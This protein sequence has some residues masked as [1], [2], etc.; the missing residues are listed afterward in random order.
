[1]TSA[2][3]NLKHNVKIL[4]AF[5]RLVNELRLP[6]ARYHFLVAPDSEPQSIIIDVAPNLQSWLI[7]RRLLRILPG[8]GGMVFEI[9]W[10]PNFH[11]KLTDNDGIE[12]TNG[13]RFHTVGLTGTSFES[14]HDQLVF[15][16][17][18]ELVASVLSKTAEWLELAGIKTDLG[19]K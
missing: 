18:A 19:E 15:S 13:T 5:W 4:S 8:Q 11:L 10:D 1:M 6:R 12:L 3:S 7:R 17:E 2:Q 14:E 16:T 9:N